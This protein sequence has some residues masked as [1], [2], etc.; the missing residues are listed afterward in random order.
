[1]RILFRKNT[2]LVQR[3]LNIILEKK[4]IEIERLDTQLDL[5]KSHD[6][7]SIRPDVLAIDKYKNY[8]DIEIQRD[9]KEASSKRC[10]YYTSILDV[11]FMKPGMDYEKLP[12]IYM[13]F[14][15]E[16]DYYQ[17]GRGIYKIQKGIENHPDLKY[18][19]EVYILYIN[20]QYTGEDELGYLMHDFNCSDYRDM[21]L[22]EM[23]ESVKK[24]KTNESEVENMCQI[25]EEL[26]ENGK[27]E[28]RLQG[29]NEGI[30][31]GRKEGML[32]GKTEGI[33]LGK[34]EEKK[35][36]AHNLYEMGLDLDKIAKALDSTINQVKEWLS[37]H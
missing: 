14:I 11:E 26:I 36:T 37:I 29:L 9:S 3:I 21:I 24:L 22:E 5:I 32:L 15:T 34:I 28:A 33:L 16:K 17:K 4:D 2:S 10:R 7:K 13:I 19:D 23:R 12:K 20:A 8:Y 18:E 25:M 30:I 27:M 6:S 31:T 35:A 1:M